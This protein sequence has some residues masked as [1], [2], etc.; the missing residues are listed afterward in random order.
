MDVNADLNGAAIGAAREK[1]PKAKPTGN[2][3]VPFC[4]PDGVLCRGMR[5][6]PFAAAFGRERVELRRGDARGCGSIL[7]FND[8]WKIGFDGIARN[9]VFCRGGLW[10]ARRTGIGATD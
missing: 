7:N 2:G 3:A 6:K 9:D 1:F 4:Y 8:R 10:A 5:T